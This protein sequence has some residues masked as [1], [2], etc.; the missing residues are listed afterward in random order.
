MARTELPIVARQRVDAGEILVRHAPARHR[1]AGAMRSV[2]LV[3]GMADSSNGWRAVLPLLPDHD[4]WTFD[5]PWSGTDG[6]RWATARR[7]AQW[8]SLALRLCPATPDVIVGHSFAATALIDWALQEPHVDVP[9][10]LLAPVFVADP[11]SVDWDYIDRFARSV[12]VQIQALLQDRL[13]DRSSPT[14]A[15]AIARKLA[16]GLMPGGMLELFSMI[17]RLSDAPKVGLRGR[18]GILVGDG[19]SDMAQA[20]AAA[21]ASQCGTP[22]QR[23]AACGHLIATSHPERV[24]AA[25]DTVL[26]NRLR[27]AA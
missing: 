1:A 10:L 2:V 19:D 27:E 11:V 14:V 24:V 26:R 7:A 15:A 22:L 20:G 25:I 8:L 13:P 4:V 6:P 18:V 21:L 5:M 3:H 23:I 17:D 12:P 16:G 9:L